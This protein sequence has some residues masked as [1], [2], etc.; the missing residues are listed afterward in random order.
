MKRIGLILATLVVI[1]VAAFVESRV[2]RLPSA[3]AV[4]AN[5]ETTSSSVDFKVKDLDDREVSLSQF[6]GRVVLVNFWAT[7]CGPCN[8]EIPWLIDLQNKYR[9][10]GF[11]V[12]GVA[13]DEEG[14]SAVAPFVQAKRFKVS[15]AAQSMNYPIVLGNDATAD[16]FGGL[17][18]LPTSVLISQDGRVVKRVDGLMSYDEIEEAIQSQLG[19]Y[20]NAAQ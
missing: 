15:G 5:K 13:M 1:A 14:R 9:A 18:G 2:V 20:K 12:L 6:K 16:K 17:V 3:Q 10:Q 4:R 7:W 8:I 11:T 19:A